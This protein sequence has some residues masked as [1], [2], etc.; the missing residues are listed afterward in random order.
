MLCVMCGLSTGGKIPFRSL[1]QSNK[2]SFGS[3]REIGARRGKKKARGKKTI[4]FRWMVTWRLLLPK[5]NSGGFADLIKG[6]GGGQQGEYHAI[7]KLSL[8]KGGDSVGEWEVGDWLSGAVFADVEA[9]SVRK[10][11][12]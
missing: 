6:E 8:A 5:T 9:I 2:C 3:A 10:G 1:P 4:T 11:W 12:S 7:L